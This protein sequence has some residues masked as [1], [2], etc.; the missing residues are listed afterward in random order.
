MRDFMDI[1]GRLHA[2]CNECRS[3]ILEQDRVTP[4]PLINSYDNETESLLPRPDSF[5][6]QRLDMILC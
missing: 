4:T 1:T 3:N 2:V 6:Q 5:M